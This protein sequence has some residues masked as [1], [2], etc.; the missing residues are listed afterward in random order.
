M[1]DEGHV[2]GRDSTGIASDYQ[3]LVVLSQVWRFTRDHTRIV[4]DG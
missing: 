4:S 1:L 2:P 3:R